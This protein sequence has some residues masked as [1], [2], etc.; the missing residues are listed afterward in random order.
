MIKKVGVL[1]LRNQSSLLVLLQGVSLFGRK[2]EELRN[3][4]QEKPE[5]FLAAVLVPQFTEWNFTVR[6]NTS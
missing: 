2:A 3:L 4:R 6:S 1:R 5:E